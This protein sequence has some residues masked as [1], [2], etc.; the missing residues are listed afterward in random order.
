VQGAV[1]LC[2]M[3]ALRCACV[4]SG[5]AASHGSSACRRRAEVLW[6]AFTLIS[7]NRGGLAAAAVVCAVV[8]TVR[9]L[10]CADGRL[11][12]VERMPHCIWAVV[13]L[14]SL[15]AVSS[16]VLRAAAQA[17][18]LDLVDDCVAQPAGVVH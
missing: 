16:L 3:T 9:S 5:P 6:V 10:G 4:F 18:R 12:C 7:S 8:G 15:A 1:C 14:V 2:W 17:P 11:K 13:C